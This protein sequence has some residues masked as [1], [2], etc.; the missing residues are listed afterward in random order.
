M[1][2]EEGNQKPRQSPNTHSECYRNYRSTKSGNRSSLV[3]QPQDRVRQALCHLIDCPGYYWKIEAHTVKCEFISSVKPQ[4][5]SS[6]GNCG[7]IGGSTLTERDACSVL[8]PSEQ[9]PK[10]GCRSICSSSRRNT[11]H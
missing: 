2:E 7:T 11:K 6:H 3:E 10:G 5:E 1:P 9:Y 8:D 4:C